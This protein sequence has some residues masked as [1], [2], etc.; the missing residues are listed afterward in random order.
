M[1][2]VIQ[3]LKGQEYKA[4]E[5]IRDIATP[6]EEV[7]IIENEKMFKHHGVWEPS[8]INLF[9][10]YI[11]TE[12]K[13]PEDFDQKLRRKYHPLKLMSVNGKITPISHK[14]EEKLLILGGEDHVVRYSQG[15]K[16]GNQIVVEYGPLKGREGEIIKTD[17]H[18]REALIKLSMF[19]TDTIVRIGL[20]IVKTLP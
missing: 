20:G 2:Y 13:R 15:F 16:Q 12:T 7:F 19:G 18:N 8:R 5:N 17:R 4:I 9:A 6:D 11:F 1:W 10:G 14:E 3:T